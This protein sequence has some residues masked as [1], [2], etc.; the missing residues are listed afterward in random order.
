MTDKSNVSEAQQEAH[1]RH[2]E[3]RKS[4]PRLPGTRI[5]DDEADVMDDLYKRFNSK[6]EAILEAA[7]FYIKKHK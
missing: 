1:Q 7:K 4:A 3:K 6:A 2:D 5:T